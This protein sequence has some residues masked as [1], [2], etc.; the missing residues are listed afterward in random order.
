MHEMLNTL[1]REH[2]AEL[3]VYDMAKGSHILIAYLKG[4]RKIPSVIIGKKKLSGQISEK[5]IRKILTRKNKR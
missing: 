3:I 4:V 2:N 1:A 5:N